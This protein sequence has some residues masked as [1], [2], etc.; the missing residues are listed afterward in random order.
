[1]QEARGGTQGRQE[2]SGKRQEAP[3]QSIL[4]S[5]NAAGGGHKGKRGGKKSSRRYPPVTLSQEAF[6]SFR[7]SIMSPK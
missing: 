5:V 4:V 3:Y 7:K 2:A 6:P 1:M